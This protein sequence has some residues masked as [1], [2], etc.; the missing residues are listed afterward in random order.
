MMFANVKDLQPDGTPYDK[1]ALLALSIAWQSLVKTAGLDAKVY[2]ISN[3]DATPTKKPKPGAPKVPR[4]PPP[5][6][7]LLVSMNTGWR[8][9]ELRDFLLRRP[10]LDSLEWDSVKFSPSD[11]DAN[12]NFKGGVL[13]KDSMPIPAG[14]GGPDTDDDGSGIPASVRAQM[15]F[16]ASEAQKKK[17]SGGGGGDADGDDL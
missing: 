9:Y 6:P 4:A 13:V 2:D 14:L 16:K 1:K 8:G 7:R 17:S 12:G 15:Q 3:P 5:P 10:E 11:L